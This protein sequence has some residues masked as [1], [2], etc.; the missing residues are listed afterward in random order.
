MPFKPFI[1][2]QLLRGNARFYSPAPHTENEI[3]LCLLA[4]NCVEQEGTATERKFLT[5]QGTILV[6]RPSSQGK[7][8]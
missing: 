2:R 5:P 1:D 8:T 3:V 4:H 6:Y 7:K